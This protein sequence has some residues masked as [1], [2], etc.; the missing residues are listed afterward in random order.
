MGRIVW[1]MLQSEAHKHLFLTDLE[2]RVLPPVLLKQFRLFRKDGAPIG[3]AAWAYLDDGT[4][5][6]I[7]AGDLKLQP[8]HWRSGPNLWLLDLIAPFG[9]DEV[10]IKELSEKVFKG[11]KFR[12]LIS[13]ENEQKCRLLNKG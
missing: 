13:G 5:A 7:R 8:E 3:Y 4:D 9:G 11:K 2:W 10:M 6:R 12:T 1:L